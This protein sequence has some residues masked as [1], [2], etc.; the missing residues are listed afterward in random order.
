MRDT[1]RLEELVCVVND[2]VVL[3]KDPSKPYLGLEHLPS[4]NAYIAGFAPSTESIS[5]NSVFT[6]GDVLFGKLRPNLR[7]AVSAP[8]DGYCSTDILVLRARYNTSSGFAGRVFQSEKVGA[9][10]ERTAVG[11][12]MPRTSWK[13]LKQEMVFAPPFQEQ[14]LIARILDTL[15]SQIRQTEV[16]IGKLE[17]IKQGLLTDLLTRGIDQNGQLRPN[18]EQ[19]PRLYKDSSLGQIPK[20]WRIANWDECTESWAMGPRFS[21]EKYTS[22]GNVATLRTTDM[23]SD[24]GINHSTMPIA[25]LDLRGL[26]QH[27]LK[28]GDFVITRSGTCGICGVFY[29]HSLPVLPGAFLIRFRFIASEVDAEFMTMLMNSSV[30]QPLIARNA[31]GGVQKNLRGT[32]LVRISFPK[33]PVNE[34]I[35]IRRSVE[36]VSERITREKNELLKLRSKKVGLMDD[37][38]TGRVR[39]TPLLEAKERPTA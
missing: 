36:S 21:A 9:A 5:T 35:K 8:F 29:G 22:D 16:L 37:L 15:D 28:V 26:E 33:P 4:R 19:A 13:Q 3:N 39:V 31:E 1:V 6:K 25:K 38:L 14:Q 23:D 27:V 2:K 20:E 30:G 18:P 7:K 10:A 12:K 11:T 34:Q 32:S 24:G 17:R